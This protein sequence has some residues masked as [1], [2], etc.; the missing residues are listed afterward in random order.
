MKVISTVALVFG[1]IIAVASAADVAAPV[2]AAPEAVARAAAVCNPSPGCVCN[3]VQGQFCGNQ[4]IN[5]A[6]TN[7]HV[8]ECNAQTGQTCDYGIRTSCVQCGK[9]SCP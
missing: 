3:K 4:A 5:Q 8:F 6:C 1:A 2:P 9:L 7:G